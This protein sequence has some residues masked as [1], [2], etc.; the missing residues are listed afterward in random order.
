[1]SYYKGKGILFGGVSDIEESDETIESVCHNDAY[2]YNVDNNKWYPLSI[3]EKKQPGKKGVQAT[4]PPPSELVESKE[5][6]KAVQPCPRFN[7]MIA[8]AKNHMYLFGGILER[9]SRE[10]TL[11]DFWSVHLDKLNEWKCILYDDHNTAEWLG[12]DSDDEEEEDEDDE[13]NSDDEEESSSRSDGDSETK[14]KTGSQEVQFEYPEDSIHFQSS[15]T[16]DDPQPGENLREYF[17]RTGADWQLR[18]IEYFEM[19]EEDGTISGSVKG[20]RRD[21]FVL[22]KDRY[23]ECLPELERLKKLAL[24]EQAEM[25]SKKAKKEDQVGSISR[26]R[27]R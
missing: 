8:I 4:P 27:D 2:Q 26:N 20:I 11:S 19:E 14:G 16:V 1:M 22:C 25:E 9:G 12:E 24:E 23:R 17:L 21:A 10:V 13:D 5:P 7:T 6:P 3:R 15:I 18:A